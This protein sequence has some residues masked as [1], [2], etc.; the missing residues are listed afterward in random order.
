MDALVCAA[1]VEVQY[2]QLFRKPGRTGAGTSFHTDNAYFKLRDPLKGVGM[3]IALDD[4]TVENGTL[5]C[6]SW[7]PGQA[8][9]AHSTDLEQ[10]GGELAIDDPAGL[11]HSAT[12]CELPAG[13]VCFFAY[14]VP[15]CTL[16]NPTPDPR[17]AVAYHFVDQAEVDA[18]V[19]VGPNPHRYLSGDR[20]TGGLREYG[21]GDG[22]GGSALT[23]AESWAA[24]VAAAHRGEFVSAVPFSSSEDQAA[25]ADLLGQDAANQAERRGQAA[26]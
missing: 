12:P 1:G 4:S 10:F 8:A 14:G 24:E 23:A 21:S 2:D 3:W 9:P 25:A 26:L 18:G 17:C 15:H 20:A 6:A 19:G 11:L 22:E 16:A 13:G 7:A 5:H